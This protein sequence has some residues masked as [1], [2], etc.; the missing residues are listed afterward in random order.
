MSTKQSGTP[1]KTSGRLDPGCQ[2]CTKYGGH[3]CKGCGK[4]GLAHGVT[5]CPDCS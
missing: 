5:R 4:G 3:T 2:E 1:K